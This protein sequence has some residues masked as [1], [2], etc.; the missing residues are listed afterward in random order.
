MKD[1]RGL[2]EWIATHLHTPIDQHP[3]FGLNLYT[4]DVLSYQK[5]IQIAKEKYIE[6]IPNSKIYKKFC[7]VKA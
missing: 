5:N 4:S 2:V 3:M 1:D 6:L 7:L